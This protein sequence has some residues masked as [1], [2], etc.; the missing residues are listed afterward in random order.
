MSAIALVGVCAAPA[1]SA[2]DSVVCRIADEH[3]T[4]ISLAAGAGASSSPARSWR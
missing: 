3:L 2:D 4:E 1:A